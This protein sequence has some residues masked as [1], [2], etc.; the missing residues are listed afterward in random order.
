MLTTGHVSGSCKH[1]NE[2][3]GSKNCGKLFCYPK[4]HRLLKTGVWS[5]ESPT[6]RYKDLILTV[7]PSIRVPVV[8][9]YP[10]TPNCLFYVCLPKGKRVFQVL[11]ACYVTSGTIDFVCIKKK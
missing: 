10:L 8:P 7:C 4:N 1:R 6:V 9:G 11:L 2:P 5:T 3:S